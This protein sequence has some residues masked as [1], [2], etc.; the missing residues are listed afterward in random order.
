MNIDNIF[1]PEVASTSEP[2]KATVKTTTLT[3]NIIEMPD[4]EIINERLETT[5]VE[6]MILIPKSNKTQDGRLD[7]SSIFDL[8]CGKNTDIILLCLLGACILLATVL[9]VVVYKWRK[10]KVHIVDGFDMLSR[11]SSASVF[12]SSKMD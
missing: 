12:N 3:E 8:E 5:T 2:I 11:G 1:V 9:A 4:G 7:L 10:E 6:N